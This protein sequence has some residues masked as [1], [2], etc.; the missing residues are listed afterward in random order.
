MSVA[1]VRLLWGAVGGYALAWALLG[2]SLFLGVGWAGTWIRWL[3]VAGLGLHAGAIAVRWISIGHPPL[4]GTF[5]T[6]LAGSWF[7]LLFTLFLLRKARGLERLA[8]V[9]VPAALLIGVHGLLFSTK[10]YPLTISERSLWVDLHALAGWWALA[11]YTL[12]FACAVALLLAREGHRLTLAGPD[13]LDDYI[14]WYVSLGFVA[15]TILIATGA[16]YSFTLFGHWWRWDPV[17]SLSLI[18]WL[19]Y[20]LA[21]HLRLFFGWRARRG[22]WMAVAC[23]AALII[24]YKGVPSLPPGSTYHLF[25]LRFP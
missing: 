14:F 3:L 25:D 8:L 19:L 1:E 12:A 10:A 9:S 6:A 7:I 4:F 11:S 24:A 2:G 21:I 20:G 23:T 22:A 16:Y 15:Q 13:L 18:S 5:E 17:E